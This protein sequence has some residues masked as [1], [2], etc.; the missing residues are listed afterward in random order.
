MDELQNIRTILDLEESFKIVTIP[1]L[2]FKYGRFKYIV[3]RPKEFQWT[4]RTLAVFINELDGFLLDEKNGC[5]KRSRS[6][7]DIYFYFLFYNH[8]NPK[9]KIKLNIEF[10]DI[11]VKASKELLALWSDEQTNSQKVQKSYTVFLTRP[12]SRALLRNIRFFIFN[13]HFC[14][15]FCKQYCYWI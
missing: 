8:E 9:I 15:L 13:A 7:G 2:P 3:I 5:R 14:F 10:D 11:N 1:L 12:G 6:N 4:F